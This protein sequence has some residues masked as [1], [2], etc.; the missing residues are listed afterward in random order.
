MTDAI[1]EYR[2]A[3]R[4]DPNFAEAHSNLSM[5]LAQQGNLDEA[6][7]EIDTA[8]RLRADR[9]DFLFNAA[10]IAHSKHDLP[11]AIARLRAVLAIDPNSERAHRM[12]DALTKRSPSAP[13]AR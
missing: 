6:Q 10:L 9:P 13:S 5:V 12:L 1:A 4:L 2:E 3:I 8:L 7:R 11:N